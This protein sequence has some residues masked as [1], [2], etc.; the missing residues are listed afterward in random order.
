VL[1]A[2]VVVPWLAVAYGGEAP[3]LLVV[4]GEVTD[5]SAVIWARAEGGREASDKREAIMGYE[6]IR[7]DTDDRVAVITF[8]PPIDAPRIA[9]MEAISSSIWMNTP[10]TRGNSC[11]MCSAISEDGVIG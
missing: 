6:T 8:K 1:L 2:G 3:A 10:P 4:A 9:P 5:R 7:Y 11:D